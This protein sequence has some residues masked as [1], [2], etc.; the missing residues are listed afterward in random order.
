MAEWRSV[1]GELPV[2]HQLDLEPAR[3]VRFRWS[4]TPVIRVLST[5]WSHHYD[6]SLYEPLGR[7][8]GGAAHAL[9]PA[10]RPRRPAGPP[11]RRRRRPPALARV[12]G[13]PRPRPRPAASPTTIRDA[14]RRACSGPSTTSRPH[15]DPDDDR[16]YRVWAGG[17][18]RRAPPQPAG[19]SGGAGAAGRS[20]PTPSTA[21]IPHPHFGTIM[22]DL[23]SIDRDA[24]EADLGLAPC[25]LR[26]GIVGAPRPGKD[27]QLVID[28]VH[29]S[30]RDDI[31]LLVLSGARR[32]RCPTTRASRCCPTS[33]C[34]AR[35]TT[36]GS[37]CLD[38][39]VLPL[40]GVV[41]PHHR[42]AR[43]RGR[44][45]A[46]VPDQRLAVPARRC[47][48]TAAIPY[49]TTAA[50]LTATIDAL[51]DATLAPA[52]RRPPGRGATPWRRPRWRRPST[53]CSTSCA[54]VAERLRAGLCSVTLRDRS[55]IDVI[56]VAARAGPGRRSSGAPTATCPPAT[57]DRPAAIGSPHRRRRAWP[58]RPTA[59]TCSR[60]RL[61][62]ATSRPC[63]TRRSRWARPNVRVW[64]DWVGPDPD[65]AG[66][67]RPS[68]P[69]LA[70]IAGLAAER[71]LTLSLEFH[72][73]TLT[74]TAA[75]TLGLLDAVDAPNLFTYWQPPTG[76]PVPDAAWRR[77]G[78]SAHRA[79][80]LHV[81][82]WRSYEDRQPLEEG[83][84]LWPA[85]L[86]EPP[87]DERWPGDRV[88]FL[89][90]VRGD[91]PDQ[92]V[93][94][95]AVLRGWLASGRRTRGLRR[96]GRGRRAV[97]G[98][99]GRFAGAEAADLL[100][101]QLGHAGQLR[102][103]RAGQVGGDEGVGQAQQ[104][105]VVGQRLGVGDVEHGVQPARRA[106]RPRGRRGRRGCRGPC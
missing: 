44:R 48:A 23:D 101:H 53:T 30:T 33:R 2:V 38:A 96:C 79:S 22:G 106:A 40:E 64:T 86:A 42:P 51:D 8:G 21:S 98:C 104:L 1:F 29:A 75:S 20:A 102:A 87:A 74:E 88:A 36:G 92:L 60:R 35:S 77:G 83:A 45:R 90:F 25:R 66:A 16:A 80:H 32:V 6:R 26:L 71:G 69:Q 56:A 62:R 39:L 7:P 43:R 82:R 95:A 68:R 27:T 41:L 4:V 47:W 31:G 97:T 63:S 84:D 5:A 49:G 3:Q 89:E 34:P 13:R 10:R 103:L 11:G 73:G 70:F 28:A 24:A 59:P 14:G 93:A 61:D 99:S 37:R 54:S 18:R 19:A 46:P 55:A 67:A 81:F 50:D 12:A 94:D 105:V 57:R 78:R 91:D 85:V 76:L 58:A 9:P 100:Q 17:R 52:P 65:A 72:P 15:D